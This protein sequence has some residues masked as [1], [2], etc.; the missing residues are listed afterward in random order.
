MPDAIGQAITDND[1]IVSSVL[2][3]NRN[4][5]GRVHPLVKANWLASPPLVVAFALAGTTRINMDREP[6]GYDG[7]NQPV[8]LK[9]IWPSSAEIAEAVARIDGEMF[10]SRY[11]DVFSGDEH[12]QKIP[13]S[14]GDTHQRNAG[15]SYVQNP[16]YFEDIGQPPA[17]PADVENARLA[18]FGDSIT[19]DH[20]S[21]AG[22]IKAS[23]PA[24]L[25]LQSLGWRRKT[26]TPTPAPRQ[27]RS[28]DARH[29]R[30]HP[31]QERDARRRGRRQHALPAEW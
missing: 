20:I 25:Y 4:F 9:D 14:A 1:L 15:S 10:R 23:S 30:Q 29:L 16:P 7:Q 22:N 21:P 11:A 3:G 8:Y 17:P 5:E 12:W 24:G 13:V 27:P 2:S 28:D 26:S 31:H 18:V 19:T 6:L